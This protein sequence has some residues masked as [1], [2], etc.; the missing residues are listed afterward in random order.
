[1]DDPGTKNELHEIYME[2]KQLPA[3]THKR[4]WNRSNPI[5][6]AIR[7][8]LFGPNKFKQGWYHYDRLDDDKHGKQNK[9]LVP[10]QL[11]LSDRNII[12]VG[13]LICDKINYFV[14]NIE[15]ILAA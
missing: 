14:P 6:N 10:T 1:M 8:T 2:R 11:K 12:F 13:T 5:G 4:Y 9:T 15:P 7:K 3:R